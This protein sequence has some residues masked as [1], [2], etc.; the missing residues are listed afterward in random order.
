MPAN[1][2]NVVKKAFLV[3]VVSVLHLYLL[4]WVLDAFGFRSRTFALLSNW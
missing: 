2:M 4:K 1:A 3:L